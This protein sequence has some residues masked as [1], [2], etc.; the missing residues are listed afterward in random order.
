M[1]VFLE[2]LVFCT[3]E[4]DS[5]LSAVTSPNEAKCSLSG[6]ANERYQ[7]YALLR[8]PSKGKATKN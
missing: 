2:F 5:S 4:T 7:M 8:K 3:I 6:L 1:G